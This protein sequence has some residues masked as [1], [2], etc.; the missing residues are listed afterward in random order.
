MNIL[1]FAEDGTERYVPARNVNLIEVTALTTVKVWW[2]I[3]DSNVSDD[4]ETLTVTSGTADDCARAIASWLVSEDLP[5]SEIKHI[6]ATGVIS[7]NIQNF[8]GADLTNC[9]YTAGS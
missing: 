5:T 3:S 6:L 7:P 4:L 9:V 8:S 1:H 2:S